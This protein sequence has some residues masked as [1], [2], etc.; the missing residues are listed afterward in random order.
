[1][2]FGVKE[3]DSGFQARTNENAVEF[4]GTI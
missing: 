4:N 1:M 3:K 2:A